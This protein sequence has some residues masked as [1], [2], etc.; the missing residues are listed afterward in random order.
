MY[1]P[2]W[3]NPQGD[4][5]A[6]ERRHRHEEAEHTAG[7]R[8]K[9]NLGDPSF[10][11]R[12]LEDELTDFVGR[13]KSQRRAVVGAPPRY[14][15]GYGKPRRLATSIGTVTVRRPR[16]RDLE[17]RYRSI[18]FVCSLSDWPWVREAY[19]ERREPS[20]GGSSGENGTRSAITFFSPLRLSSISVPMS[21][22]VFTVSSWAMPPI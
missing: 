10:I 13:R 19:T 7:Q 6:K 4:G 8:V 3:P 5:P 20:A 22:S 17:E 1:P 16:V 12:L 14:Q 18:L 11:Q 9:T 21:G 15:N 2:E